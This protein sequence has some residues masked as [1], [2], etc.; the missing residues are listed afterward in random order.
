MFSINDSQDPACA[1]PAV[2]F[3][4]LVKN[5][6]ITL[7]ASYVNRLF[8]RIMMK[9]AAKNSRF[10]D[11]CLLTHPTNILPSNPIGVD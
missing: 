5:A 4:S 8:V 1:S 6:L 3:S 2:V 9:L 7:T 10:R 11:P